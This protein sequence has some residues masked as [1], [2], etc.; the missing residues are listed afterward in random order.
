MATTVGSAASHRPET[1]RWAV[2]LNIIAML[3]GLAAFVAPGS[4][5]IPGVVIGIA[6]DFNILTLICLWGLWNL[7]RWG[8]IGAFIL[9]AL[10][11][12]S[13]LPG[14]ADP[15]SGWVLAILVVVIPMSVASLILIAH[16]SSRAAYQ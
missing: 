14:L 5:D 16:R 1:V 15:P 13:A 4:D 8:A 3:V 7:H 9:T 11:T 12:L 10:N 2:V 6:I